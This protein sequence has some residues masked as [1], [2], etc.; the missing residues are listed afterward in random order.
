MVAIDTLGAAWYWGSWRH[1]PDLFVTSRTPERLEDGTFDT[2]AVGGW[3]ACGLRKDGS[4]ACWGVNDHGQLGS[5]TKI[6]LLLNTRPGT[7]TPA[8]VSSDLQF[9]ALAASGLHTC[10]LTLSGE[11]WCWGSNSNGQIGDDSDHNRRRPAKVLPPRSAL[12]MTP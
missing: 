8:K 12:T 2:V 4:V 10:A 11:A 5:G 7:N 3:H 1:G 9:S 6:P